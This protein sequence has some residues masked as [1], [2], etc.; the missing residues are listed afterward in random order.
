MADQKL[1]EIETLHLRSALSYALQHVKLPRRRTTAPFDMDA[2]EADRE[3][4]V[5]AILA[6][7]KLN[8]W[9]V[10]H[11]PTRTH[12][13][14]DP[15]GTRPRTLGQLR[16]HLTELRVACPL[17]NRQGVYNLEKQ[18]AQHGEAALLIDWLLGLTADCKVR[19]DTPE[20]CAA[21][22]VDMEMVL[23]RLR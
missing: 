8:K 13:T 14:P 23:K 17:C 16:G 22:M 1:E 21:G 15:F 12:S 9:R 2:D 6:H 3:L 20:K 5:D 10:M 7:L 4:A 19:A 18:I 11:A